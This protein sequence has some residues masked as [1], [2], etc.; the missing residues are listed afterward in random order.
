MRLAWFLRKV[1][2][3]EEDVSAAQSEAAQGTWIPAAHEDGQRKEGSVQPP[4]ERAQAIDRLDRGSEGLR[5]SQSLR[6]QKDIRRLYDSGRVSRSADLVLVCARNQSGV[7]RILVVA[8]RKVGGAVRRNRAKRL[9]RE[10]H[11]H[12]RPLGDFQGADLAL[13]ARR[14]AAARTT[15]EI[16]EQL[17]NLYL[18]AD[19]IQAAMPA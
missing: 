3:D 16:M 4:C 15:R 8:S 18:Q 6:R 11:R 17:Y 12:L 13:I 5:C 1:S 7:C 10:A 9:L 2:G 14:E 19:L